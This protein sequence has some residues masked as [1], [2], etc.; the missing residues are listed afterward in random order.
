M[1]F[2][3]YQI[4]LL[5]D[6]ETQFKRHQRVLAVLPTGAGKTC[7]A[8]QIVKRSAGRVCLIAHRAE[9]IKQLGDALHEPYDLIKPGHHAANQRVLVASVDTLI[10]RPSLSVDT[11]IID[12][13]HHCLLGNKWGKALS[14]CPG[15][16]VLGLTA[17]PKRADGR[18][19]DAWET[20]IEGPTT[21]ELIAGGYLQRP[22]VFAP[23]SDLDR[24][25]MPD[26]ER[27]C[28][29]WVKRSTITGDV[30]EHYLKLAPCALGM[31]FATDVEHGRDL[32][33]RFT[34]AGIPAELVTAGT[35]SD[36]RAGIM[37]RFKRREILQL[38]NVDLYGEGANIPEL[39]VVSLA[40]PTRSLAVHRQQCGRVMRP[41]GRCCIIIDHVGN[42]LEH[43]LP[44]TDVLWSLSG[45]RGARSRVLMF[46][47]C[48]SCTAVYERAEA[49]CPYCGY[50]EILTGSRTIKEVVGDLVELDDSCLKN[51]LAEVARIDNPGY[52]GH[53]SNIAAASAKKKHL[54]RQRAQATLRK[55]ISSWIST[56]KDIRKQQRKFYLTFGVD[57]LTAFTFGRP[58][59]LKLANKILCDKLTKSSV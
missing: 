15:A 26:T 22:R 54:E 28:S 5:N 14:L 49:S 20:M 41:G 32:L 53:L 39:E 25:T 11:V 1:Q 21:R 40:R 7:I 38:I 36:D 30:V 42:T 24:A 50:A 23:P 16:R 6:I 10:K 57:V 58:D 8:A 44:D 29:V 4:E 9:I 51:M 17:T 2:R 55:I 43:G 56:D 13:A 18:A 45:T 27:A 52:F 12:E 35:S 33:K 48:S 34:A 31:T 47:A 19:L 37:E 3:P 59:A 46:K